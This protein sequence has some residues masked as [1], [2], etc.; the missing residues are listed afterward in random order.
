VK[1]D[2]SLINKNA[3]AESKLSKSE[4]VRLCRGWLA[5]TY[6]KGEWAYQHIRPRIIVEEL[7]IPSDN[8]ALKDY[9]MYTFHGIVKAISVGS[10]IYRRADANVFFDPNWKEFKLTKYREQVPDPLPEMPA[11][12]GEMIEV[13][14]KLGNDIDFARI[15]LY[16]TT[17]GIVLGEV[18]VYPYGGDFDSPTSCPIFNKWLG[19]QWKLTNTDTINAFWWNLA[20]RVWWCGRI[21]TS[22]IF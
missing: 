2:G 21:L 8:A 18:T 14:Q 7:L 10:A 19:D 11:S 5:R 12:L 22:F 4:A 9:R 6:S 15:D 13:A 20:Y 17:R 3:A 1:H 16:N